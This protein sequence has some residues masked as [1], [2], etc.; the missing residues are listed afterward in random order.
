[1][2]ASQPQAAII[3]DSSQHACNGIYILSENKGNLID[4]DIPEHSTRCT[5]YGAHNYIH[6]YRE[7]GIKALLYP[8]HGEQANTDCIKYKEGI[9]QAYKL[10]SEQDNEDQGNCR[11]DDIR[12]LM[13]PEWREAE[14]DIS[15]RTSSDCRYETDD[16]GTENVKILGCGK[17]Y[18]AYRK[19][20]CSYIIQNGY[21]I[22]G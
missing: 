13:H 18:A 3:Y 17:T 2:S 15:Q 16:I 11:D 19:C 7:T 9:V 22:H 21:K 6:P 8:D 12:G 20:E 4:E 1:M 5:G 10:V 14:Q